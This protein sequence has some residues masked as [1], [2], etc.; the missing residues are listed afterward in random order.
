MLYV[1]QQPY[2]QPRP[3]Q[4]SPAQPRQPSFQPSPAKTASQPPARPAQPSPAQPAQPPAWPSQPSQPAQ[5]SANQPSQPASQP[6]SLTPRPCPSSQGGEY[7]LHELYTHK[8]C[9]K[10]GLSPRKSGTGQKTIQF[11]WTYT[12]VQQTKMKANHQKSVLGC[13]ASETPRYRPK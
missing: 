7:F 6:R 2:H 8:D 13:T 10:R 5:P 9:G 4:V 12:W 11:V 1:Y 3:A